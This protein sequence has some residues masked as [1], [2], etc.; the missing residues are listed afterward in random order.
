MPIAHR[1]LRYYRAD[2]PRTE[3]GRTVADF[4]PWGVPDPSSARPPAGSGPLA[5]RLHE[6][7]QARGPRGVQRALQRMERGFWVPCWVDARGLLE[8]HG[9]NTAAYR[10][11]VEEERQQCLAHQ[12]APRYGPSTQCPCGRPH[13]LVGH[14]SAPYAPCDAPS[15]LCRYL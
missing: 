9:G 6:Q 15:P 2:P 1:D 13:C 10:A 4:S 5:A 8:E 14:D 3:D 11:A 7:A 12:P